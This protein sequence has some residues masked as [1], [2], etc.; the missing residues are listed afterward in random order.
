MRIK[1]S[2]LII[3]MGLGFGLP[4]LAADAVAAV[5]VKYTTVE[6][7]NEY[8]LP[9]GLRILLAPDASKASTTVNVTYMVGSRLESYGETGMAHLLEHMVFKGT[10]S[11]PGKTIVQEFA[12]RGMQ[13]NGTTSEDRTNY[14]EVFAASDDNLDWALKMEADRMVNSFVAR[15]DLDSEMTVVR[16]EMERGENNPTGVLVEKMLA[17]AFQWHNYGKSTIGARSDVENVNIEHLQNFYHKYYQPDNA[18]LI[19]TGKFDEAKT[20]AAI[21]KY[22]GAIPKPGRVL[23]PTYTQDPVQDGSREVLLQRVGDTQIVAALYH[24]SAGAHP[25]FAAVEVLAQILGDTPTGRLHKLLVEKKLAAS[26]FAWPAD[27]KDPGYVIFGAQL[28]KRQSRDIAKVALLGVMENIKKHPLTEA[29]LKRAKTAIL[30]DYEKSLSDPAR[31]GV[32]LSEAV[33]KGDWRLFFL[34]RDNIEKVTLADVQRVAENY[35]R[36]SN[37]TFGQ[38]IPTE[39]PVRTVIPATPDVNKLVSNYTGKAA[40]AEGEV[41]DASPANIDSRTRQLKLNNGMQIALLAKSTRGNI[42]HGEITLHMGD[43]KSLTGKRAVASMVAAMLERG[44]GKLSRQELADSL[45]DLKAKVSFNSQGAV[46]AVNFETRKDKLPE[47]MS[48]LKEMLRNPTFPPSELEQ[49]KTQAV[50]G[51]EDQMRQPQSIAV[52]AVKRQDNPYLKGDLR[53]VPTFEE[54][55]SEIKTVK[56]ADLKAFH[57]T[58][59]GGE[60]A[61]LAVVG[62]FDAPALEAQLKSLFGEWKSSQNYTRLATPYHALKATTLSFE[63]PDKQNAMYIARLSMP[64]RDDAPEY[65]AL[66]LADRIF[67]GGALKSRLADRLRQKE[68]ISYGA[69]SQFSANSL[70]VRSDMLLYASFAPQYLERV[71][72]AVAEEL[73]RFYKEGVTAQELAEA[74]TGLLQES[75][76]E[77]SE[78]GS[79]ANML[80]GNLFLKRNMA[81]TAELER[82]V[83]ATTLADVNAA[84]AKYM[85]PQQ[86]VNVYAGDFAGAAKTAAVKKE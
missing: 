16:N 47:L 37:R 15:S 65:P 78:D 46:L 67:G 1:L 43:E 83:E 77:R 57:Q 54:Q 84:I 34:K 12:K 63:T 44:A 38:F 64:L 76:V 60:N 6:G 56:P 30:N 86:V 27:Q 49:L 74:K 51:I 3:A 20:L 62:D 81:Y 70:D 82:K 85:D 21:A 31:F 61:Q 69:G 28:D 32:E 7:I 68:G 39:K 23:E 52:N 29:E 5:P 24:V 10:P 42:V 36:E 4:A 40:V 13:F 73:S 71:K 55:L 2:A 45:E 19:V 58:F 53:Y 41:F 22:F 11:L 75:K 50:A 25:D 14:F 72:T 18:A 59:F 35:F 26:V 8:R 80:A 79:L 33:A 48:L 66:L 17:S 9:N